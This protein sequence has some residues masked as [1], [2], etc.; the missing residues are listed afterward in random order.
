MHPGG[1][2]YELL[3]PPLAILASRLFRNFSRWLFALGGLGLV[4]LGLIDSSVIPIPGSLDVLT[5]L[6]SARQPDWWPYYAFMATV[7]SVA[8]GYLTYRLARKGGEETLVRRLSVARMK[9]VTRIFSRWGVGAVLIPAFLPPPMPMVPFIL[10]AGATQYP[11]KKFLTAFAIGRI[12]RYT[13]LAL[14]GAL[15]GRQILTFLTQHSIAILWTA[16]GLVIIGIAVL[17]FLRRNP[18]SRKRA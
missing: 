12:S 7:G 18:K 9:Q 17:L 14:L 16:A 15:Y 3:S 4:L 1:P 13:I 6:L 2:Q 11:L 8:G 10:A 5:I